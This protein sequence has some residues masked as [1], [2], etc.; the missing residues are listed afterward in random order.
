MG[1][2]KTVGLGGACKAPYSRARRSTGLRIRRR[3]KRHAKNKKKPSPYLPLPCPTLPCSTALPNLTL[4][5]LLARPPPQYPPRRA[6][7]YFSYGFRNT[8]PWLPKRASTVSETRWHGCRS[9]PHGFRTAHPWFPK[10]AGMVPGT[11]FHGFRNALAWF[12]KRAS[13]V[14]ETCSMVPETRFHGFQNAAMVPES[15]FPK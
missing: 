11:R 7:P 10:R 9:A 15:W 14:P 4:S 2:R 3:I 5:Y 12:P 8:P 6:L 13:M 1:V